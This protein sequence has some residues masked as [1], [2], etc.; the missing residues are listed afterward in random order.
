MSQVRIADQKNNRRMW[1]V[2]GFVL[3]VA[4]G[5]IAFA[6]APTLTVLI[7]NAIPSL[8]IRG[9]LRDQAQLMV[10]L[11]FFFLMVT[12]SALIVTLLAPRKAINVKDSDLVKTR[13]DMIKYRKME[14]TRQRKI[15]RA[16]RDHREGTNTTGKK[17]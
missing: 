2:G 7:D 9:R 6:L 8:R 15:N 16:M 12:V 5:A 14:R 10:G 3:V 11:V 1:A 4:L 17:R 13:D